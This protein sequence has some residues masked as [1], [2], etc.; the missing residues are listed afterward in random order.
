MP[1]VLFRQIKAKPINWD[2]FYREISKTLDAEVKPKLISYFD[3]VVAEWEN[4]P[5][6][7][8]RKVIRPS[9]YTVYVYP[10]GASADIWRY[11]SQGTR[12]H[13]IKPKGA[14]YPLKFKWGGKG[15]YKARTTTSG[16]YKGP[17]KVVGGKVVRFMKVNHPGNKAR[18][19]EKHIA[20][21]YNKRFVAT[22]DAAIKRGI[23]AT[24]K[25]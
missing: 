17:G 15:S 23:R 3:R 25:R 13:I 24:K 9:S 4:K 8:A 7:K 12:P 11:V 10:A 6:F 2:A 20:R 18:N 14:G 21:W 5:D 22:M 16:G 1:Q 19:F